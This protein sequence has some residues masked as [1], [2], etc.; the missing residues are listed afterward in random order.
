MPAPGGF[1][2]KG[3][4]RDEMS[5]IDWKKMIGRKV[6]I[7]Y[8]RRHE[9]E[10][11]LQKYQEEWS[12]INGFTRGWYVNGNGWTHAE[13]TLLP[14]WKPKD[15]EWVMELYRS[16]FGGEMK[17]GHTFK[18]HEKHG[19]RGVRPLA[20]AEKIEMCGGIDNLRRIVEEG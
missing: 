11:V 17:D 13:P 5:K 16:V 12:S 9:P 19:F 3:D 20:D 10:G 8:P 7:P 6:R 4:K 2:S 18:F 1:H 14:E 15:G